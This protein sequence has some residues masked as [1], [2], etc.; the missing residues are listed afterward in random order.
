MCDVG[1]LFVNVGQLHVDVGQLRVDVGQLCVYVGQLC[2][3]VGQLC[4]DV[5]RVRT[6]SPA[7]SPTHL[8]PP[9]SPTLGLTVGEGPVWSERAVLPAGAGPTTTTT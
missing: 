6:S 5:G 9:P 7:T 4:V 2:V 3:D 8:F 1:Q